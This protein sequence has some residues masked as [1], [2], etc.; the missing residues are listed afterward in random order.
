[1]SIT[2]HAPR[3][4]P[5]PA[6]HPCSS[7][8]P[9]PLIIPATPRITPATVQTTQFFL[10]KCRC[11]ESKR[12]KVCAILAHTILGTIVL[13]FSHKHTFLWWYSIF[14]NHYQE[15]H[16]LPPYEY[17]IRSHADLIDTLLVLGLDLNNRYRGL[18]YPTQQFGISFIISS[19]FD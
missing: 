10:Q 8:L 16:I 17:C 11:L 12:T 5:R 3:Y 19:L 1:M 13:Q 7:S 6:S 14:I 18:K 15:F 9:T 4:T 2:P